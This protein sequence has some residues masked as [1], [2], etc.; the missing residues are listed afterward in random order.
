[1]QVLTTVDAIDRRCAS[2]KPWTGDRARLVASLISLFRTSRDSL[3]MCH[4]MLRPRVTF[5]CVYLFLSTL[6]YS[7]HYVCHLLR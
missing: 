5:I 7:I 4:G 1:M 6:Q 3:P 2:G